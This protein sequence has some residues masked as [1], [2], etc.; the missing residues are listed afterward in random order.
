[1]TEARA[2][3]VDRVLGNC[4]KLRELAAWA[5][6]RP[7]FAAVTVLGRDEAGDADLPACFAAAG[8]PVVVRGYLGGTP[9]AGLRFEEVR[10]R[11]GEF[12]LDPADKPELVVQAYRRWVAS[13]RPMRL[14]D[15]LERTLDP[16]HPPDPELYK[17]YRN[18]RIPAEFRAALGLIRPGFLAAGEVN[19][20]CIW[21][22]AGGSCTRL[23]T[24]PND[25]FVLAVIG[26]KRFHLFSPADFANLYMQQIGASAFLRSP[27]D[28]RAP[29]FAAYP[30]YRRARCVS[31]DLRA[32]DLLFLP[33]GWPHFVE[34]LESTFT[35]NY[36]LH[37]RQVPYFKR[38]E[39]GARPAGPRDDRRDQ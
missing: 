24:D 16:E 35:Y 32:G 9:L 14:S 25:N 21:I 26:S 13:G 39:G 7:P 2:T 22:G 19:P 11:A 28:P 6:E 30:L 38:R 4:A 15:Y 12:F 3:A 5:A 27:V 31:V 18:L 20:P 17:L 23:H 29:D 36:W 33:L 37:S 34:S 8:G 10:A 1:M